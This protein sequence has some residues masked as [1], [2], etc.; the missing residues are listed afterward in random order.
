MRIASRKS[1]AT[2]QIKDKKELSK[3]LG[4]IDEMYLD[5][6]SGQQCVRDFF[7]CL[8][9]NMETWLDVYNMFAFTIVNLTICMACGHQNSFEQSQIYLE[10]DV[11]PEGSN[12]CEHVEK[13]F[14][15]GTIVE[16]KC[17]NGCK[18]KFQAEKKEVLKSGKDTKFII[19]MLRRSVLSE[20]GRQIVLNKVNAEGSI[21]IRYVK[22][23]Y[24]KIFIFHTFR[25]KDGGGSIYQ[26]IAVISH[27]GQMTR[28]GEGQGH[29]T[30]DVRIK[31][32]H[33]Y[34]TNDYEVPFPIS[35]RKLSKTCIVVLYTKISNQ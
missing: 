21:G 17:E 19:I 6:K 35:K 26:P 29:Y 14:H 10:M 18:A 5:L 13:L 23:N 32:G 30:Y 15:D 7:V 3:K 28:D 27:H 9:E 8:S 25:D 4:Q 1:E 33:W 16:Y 22:I 34:K 2:N 31:D 20:N 11:P 24:F 12:L